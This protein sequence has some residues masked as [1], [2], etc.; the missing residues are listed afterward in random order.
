[1]K[2]ITCDLLISEF[3]HVVTLQTNHNIIITLLVGLWL[4]LYLLYDHNNQSR[5]DRGVDGGGRRYNN[6]CSTFSL[7]F[8]LLENCRKIIL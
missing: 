7:K 2:V 3:R 1:L 8:W 4:L 6:F 5:R